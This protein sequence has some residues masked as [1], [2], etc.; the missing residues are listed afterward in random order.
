M[1]DPSAPAAARIPA[2][3]GGDCGRAVVAGGDAAD[4]A[5]GVVRTAGNVPD[6]GR[7]GGAPT[8]GIVVDGDLTAGID[9]VD[10]VLTAGIDAVDG[11]L[12]A[13][14]DAVDGD[15]TAGIVVD[16]DLTAGIDVVDGVLTA[17]VVVDGILTVGAVG[18]DG[19]APGVLTAGAGA[20]VDT[21]TFGG[22]VVEAGTVRVDTGGNEG[23]GWTGGP[24]IEGGGT[25]SST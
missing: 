8:A 3:D 24:L 4:A 11:D 20:L 9:V 13:G 15:L 2:D 6:G 19:W 18:D 17:G 22:R 7:A 23:S 5:A 12:T 1:P 16:G 25:E 10:G 14:I 21:I